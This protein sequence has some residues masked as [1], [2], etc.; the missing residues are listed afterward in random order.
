[1]YSCSAHLDSWDAATG[2]TDNGTGTI[3]MM[4]VHEDPE[5]NLSQS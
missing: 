2:A 4:E 5:E 3:L 1:M